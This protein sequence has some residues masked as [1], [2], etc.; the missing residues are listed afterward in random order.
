M[1]PQN[2]VSAATGESPST[3]APVTPSLSTSTDRKLSKRNRVRLAAEAAAKAVSGDSASHHADNHSTSSPAAQLTT[4]GTKTKKKIVNGTSNSI[5]GHHPSPAPEPEP[6]GIDEDQLKK[7]QLKKQKKKLEREQLASEAAN[8]EGDAPVN[9][10]GVDAEV[11]GKKKKK[12]KN[13]KKE[14]RKKEK[15]NKGKKAPKL[16]EEEEGVAIFFD[17]SSDDEIED[18]PKSTAADEDTV[19]KDAPVEKAQENEEDVNDTESKDKKRKRKKEK[20][21]IT[22]VD[23]DNVGYT[24]TTTLAGGVSGNCPPVF[25]KDSNYFIFPIGSHVKVYSVATGQSVRTISGSSGT[26]HTKDITSVVLNPS[27]QFQLFTTS[28]DG[29]IKLWDITDGSLLKS[30]NI[31]HAVT[32]IALVPKSPSTAYIYVRKG[33][34]TDGASN[35]G[36]VCHVI[37]DIAGSTHFK[38]TGAFKLRDCKGLVVGEDVVV[39]A[40]RGHFEVYFPSTKYQKPFYPKEAISCISLHPTEPAIAIGH[41]NGQIGLWYCLADP[42]AEHP[43]VSSMHWHAHAVAHIEFTSDGVYMISGGEEAVLVVWQVGTRDKRFLPRL[44]DRITSIAISPN[45]DLY[46]VSL[47]DNTVKIISSVDKTIKQSVT[48]LKRA[49]SSGTSTRKVGLSRG[50]VIEPRNNLIVLS[51]SSGCLQFY[52]ALE[53][54]HVMEVEA[55]PQNRISRTDENEIELAEVV[56]VAFST[57][58]SWMATLDV[59]NVTDGS[60]EGFPEVNLKFWMFDTKTQKYIV[61]TRVASPHNKSITSLRFSNLPG[62]LDHLLLVSS[63]QDGRFKTWQL[64][65][66]T[67]Q[68]TT[69]KT[70]VPVQAEPYW[71]LRSQGFHRDLP[72]SDVAFSA[73]SSILAVA[74]GPSL[75]LWDPL[76]NI[77]R[78]TLA[79]T[80]TKNNLVAV[81][82]VET[83]NGEPFLVALT[84]T[85]LNVWNLLTGTV[86]WSCNL[87]DNEK[88]CKAKGQF[89]AVD[90][91]T[92]AFL[93]TIVEDYQEVFERQGELGA[94]SGVSLGED[95]ENSATSKKSLRKLKNSESLER[96]KRLYKAGFKS[97]FTT[98]LSLFKPQSPVP[99]STSTFDGSLNGASFLPSAVC[100]PSAIKDPAARVL[101][102]SELYELQILGTWG[103]YLT[104]TE[105]AAVEAATAAAAKADAK[106]A[107]GLFSSVYGSLALKSSEAR[108]GVQNALEAS[109][110]IADA[111]TAAATTE[112]SGVANSYDGYAS[113]SARLAKQAFMSASSHLLPPPT[114]LVKPFLEAML[115]K[116]SKPLSQEA[117]QELKWMQ[118]VSVDAD[119]SAMEVD[120]KEEEKVEVKPVVANVNN[121]GRDFSFLLDVFSKMTLA[122]TIEQASTLKKTIEAVKELVSD[123]N[124]D[125]NDSGIALQAMDNSHVALVA[126]LLRSSAFEPYRCDQNLSLGVNVGSLAKI[127]KCADNTDIL[128]IRADQGRDTL[129]LQFESKKGDR[130][131][132]YDLKL[133]DIDSEHLGIPDT[134]YDGT[135][136]MSSVEFQRICRDMSFLSESLVID[137]TKDGVKFSA[138]GDIGNGSVYIKNGASIDD[139]DEVA[140]TIQIEAPVSLTFSLKYLINFT[141]ATPLSS[142]VCLSMSNDVPLLVEYK[143]N[144]VG[145]IRYYLA[146]KIGEDN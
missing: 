78:G 43:A 140:T 39:A 76:S 77:L 49:A 91:E 125:C 44:G 27:N 84:E 144:D 114:K 40:T 106:K 50:L 52:N 10:N 88:G 89:L 28:L 8:R 131:S 109:E 81:E 100:P 138:S 16:V 19:V 110:A 6:S 45:E 56:E 57:D 51:G 20:I 1:A 61:N 105:K 132:E 128:T 21:Q 33:Y 92:G 68:T 59:R 71:T 17:S 55:V 73:D 87:V 79:H 141:K 37:F 34:S 103:E 41:E 86:W 53:D 137:A 15:R 112:E 2:K 122:T 60:G 120:E 63:S 98:R 13:D 80:P 130:T 117:P 145:H 67:T 48:G 54:R 126:L 36:A 96:A 9:G 62:A 97:P 93:V 30:W 102:L 3:S 11:T 146:P 25:T 64:N 29:S 119:G 121:G 83:S 124:F 7:K 31:G 75:T 143:V 74:A 95:S 26:G 24:A 115:E 123:V 22:L 94:D 90:K 99:L 136:K 35:K 47:V 69:S 32:H 134:P 101:V 127:L 113:A 139:E 42:A 82:F 66:P 129:S 72:V 118:V 135:V 4:A 14:K 46:A 23:D 116:R 70:S 142:T 111:A 38:V 12:E 58:S 104:A 85:H 5:N 133:M 107:K 108:E 65:T 18:A